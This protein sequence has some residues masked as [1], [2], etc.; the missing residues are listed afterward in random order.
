M[1][2][3]RT[4]VRFRPPPPFTVPSTSNEG[5]KP[6]SNQGFRPFLCLMTCLC[7]NPRSP[8]RL[9]TGA[10][11]VRTWW[12]RTRGKQLLW[13][14]GSSPAGVEAKGDGNAARHPDGRACHQFPANSTTPTSDHLTT[15][16]RCPFGQLAAARRFRSTVSSWAVQDPSTRRRSPVRACRWTRT[17]MPPCSPEPWWIQAR[18]ISAP[19]RLV[20]TP[21]FCGSS[22]WSNRPDQNRRRCRSW[23]T[24]SRLLGLL[25]LTLAAAAGSAMVIVNTVVIVREGLARPN[26]AVAIALACFG[27]GSVLMAF[28]L[29]QFLKRHSERSVM[30]IAGIRTDTRFDRARN[31]LALVGDHHALASLAVGLVRRGGVFR[32]GDAGWS[33]VASLVSG[34]RSTGTVCRAVFTIACVLVAGVSGGWLAWCQGRH[35]GGAVGNGGAR[36]RRSGDGRANV[37]TK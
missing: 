11:V 32:I 18:W 33:V 13:S 35:S 19:K 30:L 25:A 16:Q 14:V 6:Q 2:Y 8:S 22:R 26:S 5:W 27:A 28:M 4:A 12:G 37:A 29:P 34:S 15:L 20:V 7:Q 31:C 23:P 17:S 36:R 10:L 9:A 21:H 1:E 24:R 3:L